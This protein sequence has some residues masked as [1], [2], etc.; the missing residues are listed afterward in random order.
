MGRL[1]CHEIPERTASHLAHAQRMPVP[2]VQVVVDRGGGHHIPSIVPHAGPRGS[3]LDRLILVPE[4]GWVQP[5]HVYM[6]RASV[7]LDWA[8]AGPTG[9]HLHDV[10]PAPRSMTR[11]ATPMPVPSRAASLRSH[12]IQVL[13]VTAG[14]R[15]LVS[16]GGRARRVR[17]P[18]RRRAPPCAAGDPRHRGLRDPSLMPARPEGS[19]MATVRSREPWTSSTGRGGRGCSGIVGRPGEDHLGVSVV[20]TD[21][22][23]LHV[24]P[25]RLLGGSPSAS[26]APTTPRTWPGRASHPA[27]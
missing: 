27:L 1:P 21:G 10:A 15:S 12:H 24:R 8:P 17:R 16:H 5:S 7:C 14:P 26:P 2:V 19:P 25:D 9:P 23:G 3:T 11:G 18:T 13:R 20:A 6:S 4:F 22:Q